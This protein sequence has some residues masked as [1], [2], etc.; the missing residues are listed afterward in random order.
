MRISRQ[1]FQRRRRSAASTAFRNARRRIFTNGDGR[2]NAA[3]LLLA[4]V[5][6]SLFAALI[7]VPT[8]FSSSDS[9]NNR[10]LRLLSVMKSRN[11]MLRSVTKPSIPNVVTIDH[12]AAPAKSF[13]AKPEI[14]SKPFKRKPK[15]SPPSDSAMIIFYNLFI[16]TDP[17]E[18]KVAIDVLTEQLGQVAT[19]LK[20]ITNKKPT[21][22]SAILYYNLIGN[23]STFPPE[24]INA[25]CRKLDPNLECK[26]SGFY[27]HASEAVTLEDIHDFCRQED[28]DKSTRV[29][30]IHSKGSYHQTLINMNWRR[31]MTNS[32]LH[33]D[34]QYPPDDRCDVC[35]SSFYTRFSTIY[36]GNMWTAKCSYVSKLL[37]PREGGEY[38]EKKAES[39]AKFLKY[40]LWGQLHSTLLEDRIDYFGLGRYRLE[41]WIG[42]HSSIRPC[43]LHRQNV[44]FEL[45]VTGQVKPEHYEWGMGP[46]RE[47]VVDELVDATNRLKTDEDAQFREYY[48]LPGN[49]L[50]WFTLYGSKGVPSPKS[51]AWSFFPAGNKWK[52][53]VDKHG[54]NAVEKMVM[55]SAEDFYSA[56]SDNYDRDAFEVNGEDEA[57]FADST[58]TMTVFYH[59]TFPPYGKNR[60][61]SLVAFKTQLD[62]LAT[63]QYN[64][65]S[66]SYERRRKVLLY[67]SI[68]GGDDKLADFVTKQCDIMKSRN[69]ECRKLGQFE[70]HKAKGETL[71]QL[72][73]FC[74]AKP[75]QRVTY[76][77]NQLPTQ[78]HSKWPEM[79]TSQKIRA[80]TT[81]VTSDMC[82]KSRDTCNVC[83]MEFY[84]LPYNHFTG[85]MFS[86]SCE[87]VKDLI[88]PAQFESKMNG[89]ASDVLVSQ[90]GHV[91]T[92]ELT[93]FTPQTLGMDQ[94]SVEHWIGSHP[95]F[96][97]CD[98]APASRSWFPLNCGGS[99]NEVDY[100]RSNVYDFQWSIAPRR[101]SAPH[102]RVDCKTE[103]TIAT[104]D[105]VLFREYSYLAGNLYRWYKLYN[106]APPADSWIWQ[107][108]PKGDSWFHGVE[109]HGSR[110]VQELTKPYADEGVPFRQV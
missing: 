28:T 86:A 92:T 38:D 87:Y 85:N 18:A 61:S 60:Q 49:L 88:P 100:R 78:Y 46:R 103:Q 20:E 108:F 47:E 6:V 31:E 95:D 43:E 27:E 42:S 45:M 36:P 107:W 102:G 7:I 35:G 106:K 39:V 75:S 23:E 98:V 54:E 48:Y 69:V 68:A 59:I 2:Y 15:L 16:P 64:I 89:V 56:Y 94:Y 52:Q 91:F 55:D 33:P 93:P 9:N 37:S 26:L 50:K 19:S 53:L 24:E 11:E 21:L 29:T 84:P 63:G 32:V 65:R 66:R 34:C 51:W 8:L 62:L 101:G 80:F 13:D 57:L 3:R 44:T 70:S 110:V 105:D 73:N 77:T 79:Q 5:S 40:R 81:A 82:L 83:G 109:N 67:Y 76:L 104:K 71:H 72:H 12:N 4:C 97:P 22:Q 1:S 30:Y 17:A 58:S 41:H 90:L 10:S 99:Y 14:V 74:L 96:Q 25:L